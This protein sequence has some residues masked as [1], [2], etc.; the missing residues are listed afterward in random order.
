MHLQP[1]LQ[2]GLELSHMMF[3]S[4]SQ[5]TG[6]FADFI[7]LTILIAFTVRHSTATA[8]PPSGTSAPSRM[9]E[10]FGDL[11]DIR[12]R[13]RCVPRNLRC[14]RIPAILRRCHASQTASA[15]CL[16]SLDCCSVYARTVRTCRLFQQ[17]VC[18]RAS[19]DPE[20]ATTPRFTASIACLA[21]SA[22]VPA[23]FIRYGSATAIC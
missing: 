11:S 22:N 12:M 6:R 7:G 13:C 21:T 19:V 23:R 1:L 17:P 4:I 9:A 8:L 2:Q 5:C 14:H 20:Y 3:N 18:K 15:I 16:A 10:W